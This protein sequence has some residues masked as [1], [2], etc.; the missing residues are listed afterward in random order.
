MASP[1]DQLPDIIYQCEMATWHALQHSGEA[2]IPFLTSDCIMQFPLGMNVTAVSEPTVRAILR[3]PAFLPWKE[4]DL[5]DVDVTPV[6]LDGAVISY[7]AKATRSGED[8]SYDP[9]VVF[10]ALCSSVWRIERGTWKMCFHQQ[11]LTT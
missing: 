11:T 10:E 8:P 9:D 2:L 4:F 7:M 6:G 1:E 5:L 3:S